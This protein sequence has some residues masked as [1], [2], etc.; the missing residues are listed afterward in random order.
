MNKIRF[1]TKIIYNGEPY[2]CLKSEFIKPGK[3]KPFIRLLIKSLVSEKTLEK[4]F[5]STESID[6]TDDISE[7]KLTYI[8]NNTQFWFFM[9]EEGY[10]QFYIAKDNLGDKIDWITNH[11]KCD[12]IFWRDRLISVKLPN[13]VFLKVI[14]VMNQKQSSDSSFGRKGWKQVMLQ[15]GAIIK[16]PYFIKVGDIIKINTKKRSYESREKINT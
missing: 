9:K 13:F 11:L 15:T 1:G 5:K 10:D 6:V 2:T 12:V 14:K 7:I 3:G 8:Y 4:T 16:V